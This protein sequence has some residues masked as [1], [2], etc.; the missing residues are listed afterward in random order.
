MAKDRLATRGLMPALA[1]LAS[2]VKRDGELP[3]PEATQTIV[4][5][6]FNAALQ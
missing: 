1:Q 6:E 3:S 5:D 2:R 4:L